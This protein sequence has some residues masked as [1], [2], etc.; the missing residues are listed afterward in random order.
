MD[1]D[2]IEDRFGIVIACCHGGRQSL[3]KNGEKVIHSRSA[4]PVP[5]VALPGEVT[6]YEQL[7]S[8]ALVDETHQPFDHGRFKG[9]LRFRNLVE[10]NEGATPGDPT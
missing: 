4:G 8:E 3:A 6:G 10:L 2:P 9:V 1:E 5:E 7:S